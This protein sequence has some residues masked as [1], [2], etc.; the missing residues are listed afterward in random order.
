MVAG[1]LANEDLPGP[2][3]P[4]LR[5]IRCSWSYRVGGEKWGHGSE[6]E[7]QRQ[8]R[9]GEV[10]RRP[11]PRDDAVEKQTCD[12]SRVRLTAALAHIGSIQFKNVCMVDVCVC[13][14]RR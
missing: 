8:Q 2:S 12:R 1:D 3:F 10:R 4:P 6:T 7:G 9:A 13:G 5:P 14:G 11:I